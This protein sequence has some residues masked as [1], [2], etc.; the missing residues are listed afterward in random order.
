MSR[1][2][3]RD[4]IELD[5]NNRPFPY[6]MDRRSIGRPYHHDFKVDYYS[7]RNRKYD[8]KHWYKPD[9]DYK[10]VTKKIRK[11]KE[12]AAMHKK[13]YDNIPIFKKSDVWDWN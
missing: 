5:D 10:K 2:Y 3:R 9:K 7:K 13:R 1:T 8:K 11:A 4:F 6:K 12:R